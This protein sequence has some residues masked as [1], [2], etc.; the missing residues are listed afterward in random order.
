MIKNQTQFEVTLKKLGS[1][2]EGLEDLQRNL[3]PQNATLFVVQAESVM[4]DLRR[5]R[6]ELEDYTSSL[7][8]A[9]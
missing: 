9:G 1:L 7:K 4:E 2:L 8:V 3:L 5:L 6:Q